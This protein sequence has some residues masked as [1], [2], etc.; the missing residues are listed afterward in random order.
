MPRCAAALPH[1]DQPTA[2]RWLRLRQQ[3]RQPEAVQFN[4]VRVAVHTSVPRQPR[5]HSVRSR[6]AYAPSGFLA[7]EIFPK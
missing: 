6:V 7:L 3:T 5:L 4:S 2:S 1:F